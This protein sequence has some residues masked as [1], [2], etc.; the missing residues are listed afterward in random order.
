[1]L[2]WKEVAYFWPLSLLYIWHV[3]GFSCLDSRVGCRTVRQG[4]ADS[5]YLP[6]PCHRGSLWR[7]G[8][9]YL[10]IYILLCGFLCPN[11]NTMH[12]DCARLSPS[13]NPKFSTKI[14]DS[15]SVPSKTQE[16]HA[17]RWPQESSGSVTCIWISWGRFL[18]RFSAI[19]DKR[20]HTSH[21]VGGQ[22][23]RKGG[24]LTYLCSYT[25]VKRW[26]KNLCLL[27]ASD[28]YFL[29]P[30]RGALGHPNTFN[31]FPP[32]PF[33]IHLKW[34]VVGSDS[35]KVTYI[36]PYLVWENVRDSQSKRVSGASTAGRPPVGPSTWVK[37]RLSQATSTSLLGAPTLPESSP[38]LT[39]LAGKGF[40]FAIRLRKGWESQRLCKL[41]AKPDKSF[42]NIFMW[43]VPQGTFSPCSSTLPPLPRLFFP[44]EFLVPCVDLKENA[45]C[46]F[47]MDL[48]SIPQKRMMWV[49]G[50]PKQDF[51]PSPT[52]AFPVG[53]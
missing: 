27:S 3:L 19:G 37:C 5:S 42:W 18:S 26:D 13:D 45:F 8:S 20:L 1:M 2:Y 41:V 14:P 49:P 43:L 40:S 6:I 28:M 21:F 29:N 16:D 17:G 50:K 12:S 9:S 11:F 44:T 53:H 35:L 47:L 38:N 22:E 24:R 32:R 39:L 48:H 30:W 34:E 51:E 7:L 46:V 23:S 36:Q 15:H 33:L 31:N 10:S 52:P 4:I 25:L